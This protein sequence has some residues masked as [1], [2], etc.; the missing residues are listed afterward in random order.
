[1]LMCYYRLL[2]ATMALLAITLLG[3][4][5]AQANAA[6][7]TFTTV[8]VP[9]ATSGT[10]VWGINATGQVTGYYSN[11]LGFVDNNG[12][13][14]DVTIPGAR[15]TRPRGINAAGQVTG[16]Y[17]NL[18]GAHGFVETNGQYATFDVPGATNGTYA[19]GINAAG[20]V[21]GYYLDRNGTHG[22][23]NNNGRFTTFDV[24]GSSG[25]AYAQGINDTGQVTG[26]Y[27]RL[28]SAN[29]GYIYDSYGFVDTNDVFTTFS[30]PNAVQG[31]NFPYGINN[32]GQIVGEYNDGTNN[33]ASFVDTNGVFDSLSVP[34]ATGTR[35]RGINDAGQVTG[36]YT[37]GSSDIPHG[38]VA[39]LA[40]VPPAAVP[41]PSS[42]AV[43][44]LGMAG[45]GL[46]RRRPAG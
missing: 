28:A 15:A 42:L 20:Q 19:N 41:E 43:L 33:I 45:L 27:I 34:G 9:G 14:T 11:G 40:D 38:F 21:T 46:V 3:A 23:V 35:A 8:D 5:V 30:V 10:T 1:M 2:P 37:T 22:F 17:Y 26:S 36:F 24:P 31:N 7:Y 13:F 6:A 44:A 4:T 18:T 12:V 39:S 32:V 29:G 16:Y 25:Y